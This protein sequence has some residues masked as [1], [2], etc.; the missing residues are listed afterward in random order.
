MAGVNAALS[1][2]WWRLGF[3]GAVPVEVTVKWAPMPA[4]ANTAAGPGVVAQAELDCYRVQVSRP[5][6]SCVDCG[7]DCERAGG[8]A[9]RADAAREQTGWV[10]GVWRIDAAR[11]DVAGPLSNPAPMSVDALGSRGAHT[12]ADER[13]RL[14][15]KS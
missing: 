2:C 12:A 11:F 4:L 8:M 9:F 6:L 15:G 13:E 7:F 1:A 10:R 5:F 14:F 3:A